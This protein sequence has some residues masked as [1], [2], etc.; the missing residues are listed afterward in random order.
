MT[1]FA[2]IYNCVPSTA[3]PVIALPALGAVSDTT[4][5]EV[6]VGVSILFSTSLS[7]KNIEPPISSIYKFVLVELDNSS[8]PFSKDTLYSCPTSLPLNTSTPLL[9]QNLVNADSPASL[10]CALSKPEPPEKSV[11]EYIWPNSCWKSSGV[12]DVCMAC[13]CNGAVFILSCLPGPT[14][15]RNKRSSKFA[16]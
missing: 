13:A 11:L 15:K 4:V 2:T 5:I 8:V 9:S 7:A 16:S 3:K 14:A 10:L 1:P 12:S 6:A